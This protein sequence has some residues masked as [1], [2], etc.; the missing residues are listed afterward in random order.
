MTTCHDETAIPWWA[1]AWPAA[2]EQRLTWRDWWDALFGRRL[3]LYRIELDGSWY[4]GTLEEI[5][6]ELRSAGPDFLRF[7]VMQVRMTRRQFEALPEFEG[8]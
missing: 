4:I 2:A 5:E 7:T 1:P 3:T 6:D 8:F